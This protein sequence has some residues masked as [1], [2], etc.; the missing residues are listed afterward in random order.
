MSPETITLL[1]NLLNQVTLQASAP[2]FELAAAA[3]V[4]ARRELEALMQDG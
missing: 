1:L 3:I 4:A 2:N